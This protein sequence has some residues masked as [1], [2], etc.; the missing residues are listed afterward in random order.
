MLRNVKTAVALTAGAVAMGLLGAAPAA[1]AE[2]TVPTQAAPAA[3]KAAANSS[4]ANGHVVSRTSLNIRSKPTTH[5]RVVGHLHSGAY[6]KIDCKVKGQ[7]VDGNHIWYKLE[8]KHGWVTARYVKNLRHI[9][10]C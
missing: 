7:Y 8:H 6:I 4:W 9:E 1:S 2:R 10:W 5:S 3:A